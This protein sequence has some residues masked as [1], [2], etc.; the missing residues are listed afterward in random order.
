LQGNEKRRRA[1]E[2]AEIRAVASGDATAFARIIDREAPRLLRF[3]QV[4]LGS[5][6]EAEDVVQDTMLRLWENAAKWTPDARL[7]TWLHRVCYNRA[8]DRLRR[9]RG[10]VEESELLVVPDEGDLADARVL[11][12]EI[13]TAIRQAMNA[14]P[15]RQRTAVL[16]FHFQELSQRE[17]AE[18]MELSEA[19]FE[20][21]LAR[22]RRRLRRALADEGFR[23]E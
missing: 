12:G 9:R 22:A 17:C 23:D 16:L 20:S 11:Q 19:A 1:A 6:E 21:L 15:H 13:V 10:L 7:G 14:L 5:L 3:A 4:M 18:I 2:L 8:I